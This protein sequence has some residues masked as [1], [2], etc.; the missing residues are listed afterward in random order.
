[1]EKNDEVTISEA[2]RV[3]AELKA[4]ILKLDVLNQDVINNITQLQDLNSKM[5]D[6]TSI[7]SKFESKDEKEMV[8]NY[9]LYLSFLA[10]KIEDLGKNQDL[11]KIERIINISNKIVSLSVVKISVIVAVV[12]TALNF[13]IL[14]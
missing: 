14:K 9:S 3:T 11:K 2:K 1:M 12:T 8:R 5:K 13:I 7:I 10:Q 6:Y 4:S